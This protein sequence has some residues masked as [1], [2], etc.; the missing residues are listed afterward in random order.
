MEAKEDPQE[1]P[2]A[3]PASPVFPQLNHYEQLMLD[4]TENPRARVRS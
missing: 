4:I 3:M 1:Q 2:K